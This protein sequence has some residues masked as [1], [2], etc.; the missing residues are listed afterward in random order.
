MMPPALGGKRPRQ[1]RR[2]C[3]VQRQCR[4]AQRGLLRAAGPALLVAPG[5]VGEGRD[6][7]PSPGA[8]RRGDVLDLAFEEGTSLRSLHSYEQC[9]RR[10]FTRPLHMLRDTGL[11]DSAGPPKHTRFQADPS[12]KR[13]CTNFHSSEIQVQAFLPTENVAPRGI[14]SR[15]RKDRVLLTPDPRAI[16]HCSKDGTALRKAAGAT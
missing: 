15:A 2:E 13:S 4:G 6:E 3:S 9:N 8:G 12:L 10:E 7:Q 5:A 11:L 1:S 16:H 14:R